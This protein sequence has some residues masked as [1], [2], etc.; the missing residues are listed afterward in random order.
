VTVVYFAGCEDTELTLIGTAVASGPIRNAWVRQGYYFG[1]SGADPPAS[2]GVATFSS[3]Q[4][5]FWFHATIVPDQAGG[6]AGAQILRFMDG[7]NCRLAIRD[8]GISA[9]WAV[10]TRTA[11]GVFTQLGA[12]FTTP[13]NMSYTAVNMLDVH[14]VYGTSGAFTVF[15]NGAQVFNISGVNITTDGATTLSAAEIAGIAAGSSNTTWSEIMV[16][17]TDT[18]GLGL[19]LLNSSVSGTNTQ[20]AGTASNVNKAA[21]SDGTFITSATAGQINEYK[22]GGLAL[23]S[24][25]YLVR[26]VVTSVRALNATTGPQHVEVGFNF[27]GT[28]YWSA[29]LTLTT[30]FGNAMQIWPNSPNTGIAWTTAE[31]MAAT[32][33]YGVQS[34]A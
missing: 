3:P 12:N 25:S 8:T 26:A 18:R 21:I 20:W 17:D 27:N 32:F 30:V 15:L 1:N 24:G 2:R 19:F 5:S 31:I 6:T 34:T 7:A 14:V 9:T 29:D 4:S 16:L 10:Y 28:R 23:P 33:N 22:T 11:A 13:G